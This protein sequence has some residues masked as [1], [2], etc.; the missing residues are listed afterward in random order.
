MIER[1][2][3]TLDTANHTVYTYGNDFKDIE[4]LVITAADCKLLISLCAEYEVSPEQA[5]TDVTATVQSWLE[6]GVVEG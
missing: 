6:A 1:D 2:Y 4:F 3:V 5:M